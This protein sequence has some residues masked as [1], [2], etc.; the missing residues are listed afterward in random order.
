MSIL[1]ENN[2]MPFLRL[3]KDEV[4]VARELQ[5]DIPLVERPFQHIG[6]RT[7]LSES[8]VLSIAKRLQK[9][10]IIRKFGAIVRHQMAGYRH[11]MMV[12]WAV[13]PSHC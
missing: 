13:S 7:G 2:D 11:N 8:E 9:Q 3:T 12:M 4:N 5:G 1:P 6:D 10:H